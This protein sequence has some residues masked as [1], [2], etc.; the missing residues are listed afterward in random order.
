MFCSPVVRLDSD[1][2]IAAQELL[3]L[4]MDESHV[5][6]PI[7]PFVLSDVKDTVQVHF[8]H[9]VVANDDSYSWG[10]STGCTA[11]GCTAPV[12]SDS[13]T[14]GHAD[15]PLEVVTSTFEIIV[16]F[17]FLSFFLADGFFL[18]HH[19]EKAIAFLRGQAA[20][21]RIRDEDSLEE[22]ERW[23]GVNE[24]RGIRKSATG[25]LV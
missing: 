17:H 8:F 16:V 18:S 3:V 21:H 5:L 11:P 25:G 7:S 6:I 23:T 13:G 1:V 10:T 24:F 15:R 20:K 2:V 4:L 22:A 14:G 19:C 9:V 12:C